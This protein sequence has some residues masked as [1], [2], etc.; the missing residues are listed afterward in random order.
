MKNMISKNHKKRLSVLFCDLISAE[1]L[2]NFNKKG[3]PIFIKNNHR[4]NLCM[5]F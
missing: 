4:N 3:K 1:Y 5:K 2:M